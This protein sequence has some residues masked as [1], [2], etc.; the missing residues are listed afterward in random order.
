MP[1]NGPFASEDEVAIEPLGAPGEAAP[2][3][4][5][6]RSSPTLRAA[7]RPARI[8]DRVQD[9]PE[10]PAVSSGVVQQSLGQTESE[11]VSRRLGGLQTSI[12]ESAFPA[13]VISTPK[14][15]PMNRRDPLAAAA[16]ILLIGVSRELFKVWRRQAS[17]YWPA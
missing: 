15:F 11:A 12:N 17:D 1:D 6:F 7:G 10:S 4:P 2:V 8:N 13:T 16:L 5:T 9:Y 14:V 3:I